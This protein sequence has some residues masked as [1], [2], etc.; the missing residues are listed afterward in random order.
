MSQPLTRTSR[1]VVDVVAQRGY[2][3]IQRLEKRRKEIDSRPMRRCALDDCTTVLSRY[4]E[5]GYCA[6]HER[7]HAPIAKFL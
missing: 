1:S 4:N 2:D 3:H 7:D 6:K 5:T